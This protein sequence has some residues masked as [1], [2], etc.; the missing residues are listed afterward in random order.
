MV[1]KEVGERKS[2]MVKYTENSRITMLNNF[3]KVLDVV[4]GVK[5]I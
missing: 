5:N 1:R 2:K 3:S 4:T